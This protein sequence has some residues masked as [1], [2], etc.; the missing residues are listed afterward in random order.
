MKPEIDVR[1]SYTAVS[2]VDDTGIEGAFPL[3][4]FKPNE[5]IE[6]PVGAGDTLEAFTSALLN[7]GLTLVRTPDLLELLQVVPPQPV[8]GLKIEWQRSSHLRVMAVDFPETPVIE[9]QTDRAYRGVWNGTRQLLFVASP[10]ID[11]DPRT[12]RFDLSP[13]A[14]RGTLTAGWIAS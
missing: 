3:F 12:H 8:P 11:I 14:D 10:D 1:F 13:A 7:F 9:A 2:V 4:V 5:R 6:I